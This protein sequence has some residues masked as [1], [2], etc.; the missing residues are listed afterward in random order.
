MNLD[1]FFLVMAAR[2]DEDVAAERAPA[3]LKSAIYSSLVRRQAAT[4]P[5]LSLSATK[6]AGHALCVFEEMVRQV[7]PSERVESM[8]PCRIC[9]ARVLGEHVESPPIFWRHCPYVG[10]RNR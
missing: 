9:H 3:Q 7:A 6:A 1:R 2:T 4:G 5:L 10:F 8:N